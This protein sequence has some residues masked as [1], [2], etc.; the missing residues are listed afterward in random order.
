MKGLITALRTLTLF[1]IPGRES[2]NLSSSLPWFPIVGLILGLILYAIG[3]IWI[4]LIAGDWPE[5]GAAILLV[6]QV[7]L[8]R[9]L[10]LDG[11]AD[12]ADAL[13]GH[14]EKE[15]RLSIMKDPHVGAFGILAL[16][17]AVLLKWVAFTR[18]LSAGSLLWLFPVLMTSRSMI[19]ELITT[20]PYARTGEGMARP[21]VTGA[22]SKHRIMTHPISLGACLYFGFAGSV[23]FGTGWIITRLLAVSYRKGFGGITGDLLGTTNEIVEIILLM[24]CLLPGFLIPR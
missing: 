6:A 24:I 15:P 10:H 14:R 1:P 4:H 3:A 7:V 22:S 21:F 20:L 16:T 18:L 5:A 17:M 8:T 11:L 2:D 23:L 19:V 12:W 9:G 13:G